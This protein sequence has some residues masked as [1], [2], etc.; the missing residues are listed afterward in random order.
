[1][2]EIILRFPHIGE[3]I[4]KLL[5]DKSLAESREVSRSWQ[6]FINEENFYKQTIAKMI[7]EK[8]QEL[9]KLGLRFPPIYYLAISGQT[10]LFFEA[11]EIEKEK[12]PQIGK[13]EKFAKKWRWTEYEDLAIVTYHK[14]TWLHMI[15]EKG[16]STIC[17][18]FIDRLENI[19]PPDAYGRTPFHIAA[20]N[21]HLQVCKLFIDKLGN[22]LPLDGIKSTPFHEAAKMGHLDVCNLIIATNLKNTNPKDCFGDTPLHEAA[23]WGHIDICQ[24]I[25]A[26]IKKKYF[27]YFTNVNPKNVDGITPLHIAARFGHLEICQL[28]LTNVQKKNPKSNNN[29]TPL[30]FATSNDHQDIC[31]L[32]TEDTKDMYQIF[33]SLFQRKYSFLKALST[34]SDQQNEEIQGIK[35]SKLEENV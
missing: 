4:F 35:Y 2:E 17:K 6:K 10:G 33:Q 9:D 22:R 18:F 1:M 8:K 26:N 11:L 24:S 3:Q 12:N 21:G 20:R 5:D 25:I 23:R 19:N 7:E 15:A 30:Y 32:L 29:L 31:Q 14:K 34:V 27:W 16:F 13:V 28:L